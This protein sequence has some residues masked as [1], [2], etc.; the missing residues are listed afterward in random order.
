MKKR[1]KAL[2]ANVAQKGPI[3]TESQLAALENAK[4]RRKRMANSRAN[5]PAIAA[6]RTPSTSAI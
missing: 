4:A 3:L 5:A 1:L 2:K 6:V